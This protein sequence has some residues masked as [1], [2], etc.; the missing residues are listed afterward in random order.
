M[1]WNILKI[2]I[3]ES[4]RQQITHNLEYSVLGAVSN[5]SVVPVKIER[6]K[7]FQ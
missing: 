3:K 2:N 7:L 5:Y 1:K 4:A 6:R